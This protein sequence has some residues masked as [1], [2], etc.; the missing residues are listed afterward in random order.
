MLRSLD[1]RN[2]G[3][4]LFEITSIDALDLATFLPMVD[5]AWKHDYVD[6]ARL[7]H[8]LNQVMRRVG[9]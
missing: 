8:R 7:L 5:R 9:L 6:D 4:E 1:K 3:Y 2:D